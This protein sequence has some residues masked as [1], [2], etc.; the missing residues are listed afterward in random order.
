MK[1]A[2]RSRGVSIDVTPIPASGEGEGEREKKQPPLL[3]RA[4]NWQ[5]PAESIISM[6]S[7]LSPE[8]LLLLYIWRRDVRFNLREV[9]PRN[10]KIQKRTRYQQIQL[11]L[12][13]SKDLI[14]KCRPTRAF[15][16]VFERSARSFPSK[17]LLLCNTMR[18]F[19]FIKGNFIKFIKRSAKDWYNYHKKNTGLALE[20]KF[21]YFV[22]QLPLLTVSLEGILLR[23]VTFFRNAF[24]LGSFY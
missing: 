21:F 22:G 6:F 5:R 14:R 13:F 18:Y 11:F 4:I 15:R 7:T 20:D 1:T 19:S 23:P 16:E 9:T 24:Y 8:R 17:Y 2:A 12:S 3:S 10:L